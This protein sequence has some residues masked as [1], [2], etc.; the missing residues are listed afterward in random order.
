MYSRC[1]TPTDED[2]EA[3]GNTQSPEEADTADEGLD[4]QDNTGDLLEN[5]ARQLLLYS[6][7]L[8]SVSLSIN[9]SQTKFYRGRADNETIGADISTAVRLLLY[10]P[11]H[12]TTLLVPKNFN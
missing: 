3:P 4:G 5:R 9:I 12:H 10:Q 11:P 8:S 7:L 6:V 1:K 2:E